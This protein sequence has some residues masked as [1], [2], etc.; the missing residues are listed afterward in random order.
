M[1]VVMY[2]MQANSYTGVNMKNAVCGKEYKV[3]TQVYKATPPIRF[4]LY[5]CEGCIALYDDLLCS[6][7]PD[8]CAEIPVIF[9][10]VNDR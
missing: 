4:G 5:G 6:K 9:V 10:E 2:F 8:D 1:W 3:G 7:L